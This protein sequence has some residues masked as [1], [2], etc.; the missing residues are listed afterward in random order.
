MSLGMAYPTMGLSLVVG[1]G[2]HLIHDDLV[3]GGAEAIKTNVKAI[4]NQIARGEKSVTRDVKKGVNAVEKSVADEARAAERQA[5]NAA[6][7]VSNEAK[8]ESRAVK[9]FFGF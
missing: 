7:T 5:K 4:G 1:Y 6:N 2:I 8:R 9:K 3:N